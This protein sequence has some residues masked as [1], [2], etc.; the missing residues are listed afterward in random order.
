MT[1]LHTN[2]E[3]ENELCELRERLVAMA[4][5]VE[6]MIADSINALFEGDVELARQTIQRDYRVNHDEMEID[7]LCLV[8][9]AKRQPLG[10][11]LRFITIVLKMV[12]DL[13]RIGDLAVNICERVIRLEKTPEVR[14]HPRIHNM[15][16]EVQ[17]MIRAAIDAFVNLDADSAERVIAQDD[18]VDELYHVV[19]RDLL[20]QMTTHHDKIE[21]LIH[22]QSVAKWLERAG[23]HCTNLAELVVFLVRG[24]DIRHMGK[25][26]QIKI[27]RIDSVIPP[28]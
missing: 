20:E 26:D 15:A 18:E 22:I 14:C 23:D 1:K 25:V 8:L 7:E 19:F 13:E 17:S 28:S 10:A 5:R 16:T 2:R 27:A 21:S 3:Y 4:S 9:L 6:N 12:T 24:T 11:D